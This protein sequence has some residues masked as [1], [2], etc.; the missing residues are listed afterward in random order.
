MSDGWDHDSAHGWL[1]P[2]DDPTLGPTNP[3]RIGFTM[4]LAALNSGLWWVGATWP[5]YR[6]MQ[7][8]EYRC[9]GRKGSYDRYTCSRVL[10]HFGPGG[11]DQR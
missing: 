7:I 1:D 10:S 3:A 4:R 11:G 6:V 2:L 5:S 8:M 9:A